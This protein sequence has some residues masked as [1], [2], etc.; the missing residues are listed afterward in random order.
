[1]S[2]HYTSNETNW[3]VQKGYNI[4]LRRNK[5]SHYTPSTSDV[6]AVDNYNYFAT[7]F[8]SYLLSRF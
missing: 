2:V 5:M 7:L 1:M 6:A 8:H 4:T 3:C